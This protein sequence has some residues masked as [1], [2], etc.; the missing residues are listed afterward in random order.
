MDLIAIDPLMN[1]YDEEWPIRSYQPSLPPPKFVFGSRD[2]E[3]RGFAMDSVVCQGCIVSG[4]EVVRSILGPRVRVNS[5]ATVKDS[6]LFEGV[7][8]GRHARIRRAILDK[9][10]T[11]P[12][13]TE[14]G[15]D[16]DA[17]RRRGFHVSDGGVVVLGKETRI[18]QPLSSR[19]TPLTE[20]VRV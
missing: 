4:G 17:D 2:R 15:H 10:V 16:L 8:I 5:F 14:I 20:A 6:I 3:G 1:M 19:E 12:P 7:N 13:N 9:G 11:I 18:D